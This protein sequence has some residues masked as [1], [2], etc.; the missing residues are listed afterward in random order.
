MNSEDEI[1]LNEKIFCND[2]YLFNYYSF[3]NK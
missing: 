2:N 1:N 3:Y